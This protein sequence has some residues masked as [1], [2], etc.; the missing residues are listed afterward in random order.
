MVGMTEKLK[1]Q[2]FAEKYFPLSTDK[3]V[4]SKMIAWGDAD[5]KEIQAKFNR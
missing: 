4:E 2:E 5:F 3:K 1:E